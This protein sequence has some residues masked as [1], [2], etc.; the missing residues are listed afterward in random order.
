MMVSG[1]SADL[2]KAMANGDLVLNGQV[3]AL[4]PNQYGGSP[5][6]SYTIKMEKFR[7]LPAMKRWDVII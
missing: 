7:Y 6:V 3:T 5:V 1:A 2:K 4:V